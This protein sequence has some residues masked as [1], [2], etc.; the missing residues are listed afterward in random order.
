MAKTRKSTVVEN[1]Q[2]TADAAANARIRAS[3][4]NPTFAEITWDSLKPDRTFNVR[5][6][7]SYTK[8]GN[9]DLYTSLKETGFDRSKPMM[10][11]SLKP[12]GTYLLLRGYVRHAMMSLIRSETDEWNANCKPEETKE[13][14]FGTIPVAI[15]GNA[16]TGEYLTRDQE[17]AIMA[18]HT[19]SRPLNNFER[20][21][22][23]GRA[24]E[25]A[26]ASGRKLS[27]KV[28][29]ANLGV[30]EATAQ[31]DRYTYAM[32]TVYENLRKLTH[33]EDGA[34]KVIQDDLHT[35]YKAYQDDQA[36]LNS[37]RK[38]GVNFRKAWD[39]VRTK[40]TANSDGS[41]PKTKTPTEI[42]AALKGLEGYPAD[43][44]ETKMMR[45]ALAWFVGEPT[46][47]FGGVL[48]DLIEARKSLID[49]VN[50]LS[51]ERDTLKMALA[52]VSNE[53][54]I[55]R[56]ERDILAKENAILLAADENKSVEA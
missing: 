40:P 26:V 4:P 8:A 6:E 18:D 35:L 22:M 23:I 13:V 17:T 38:E 52:E 43:E 37:P 10:A 7:S 1:I 14:P 5:E 41:K 39:I 48:E 24:W 34:I 16:E 45:E 19:G 11:V 53:R 49:K 9:A 36:V 42:N 30:S 20:C 15:Y 44:P 47:S 33:D 31:R 2:G 56:E 54:D 12:D 21:T 32:P 27:D 50:T 3:I 55:L 29:A 28:L 25:A 46:A 51:D